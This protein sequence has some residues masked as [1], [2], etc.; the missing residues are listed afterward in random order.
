MW[1]FV[2]PY[3]FNVDQADMGSKINFIFAGCCFF[4]LYFF[5][6]YL[7]ETANR[8]YEEVDEMFKA[9]VPARKWRSYVTSERTEAESVYAEQAKGETAHIENS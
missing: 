8:S 2:L 1:S 4:S 7:P 5:Y 3:M 6:F 9:N